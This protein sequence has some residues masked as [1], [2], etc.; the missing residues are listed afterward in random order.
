MTHLLKPPTACNYSQIHHLFCR[1]IKFVRAQAKYE[2]MKNYTV[3]LSNPLL[4]K[5]LLNIRNGA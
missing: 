3:L 5:I 2:C 1:Q 4:D